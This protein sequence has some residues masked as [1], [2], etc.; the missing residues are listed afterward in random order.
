MCSRFLSCTAAAFA[1]LLAAGCDGDRRAPNPGP[2]PGA[3]AAAAGA[4]GAARTAAPPESLRVCADP[5]NLPFSNE[6]G[7]GFENRIASLIAAELGV[8]LR[9]TWWAQRRGFVRSTLKAGLC[10]VVIGVPSAMDMLLTTAP[11]YRSAYV[12]ATRADRDLTIRSFDDP[13]LR[14]LRVGVQL[15]GDDGANT[16]PAHALSRRRITDRVVGYTVYGNYAEANPSA[17]ILEAVASGDVDVA[18]VWG[19][20]AGYF[21]TRVSHPLVLSAVE[22]EID[23]P[24]LLLAWDIGLGVRHGEHEW[25]DRLEAVLLRR[26]A[27]IEAILEEFGVPRTGARERAG[28]RSLPGR[29]PG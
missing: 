26:R 3:A 19:P 16:P 5:N 1:L 10:D 2:A 14:E 21:A 4:G 17:R 8:P 15:V 27:D 11:Y 24:F 22:P 23:P 25:K 18:I 20:L 9:Y 29:R 12:F 7:E 28:T 13:R 6:A